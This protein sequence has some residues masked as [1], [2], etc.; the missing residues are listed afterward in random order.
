M[1]LHLRVLWTQPVPAEWQD[2]PVEF[3]MQQGKETLVPGQLQDDGTTLYETEVTAYTDAK[4]RLRYRGSCA[5]G[6]PEE[7][8][9][10]LSMRSPRRAGWI[11]RAKIM[12]TSLTQDFLSSLPDGS[13]LETRVEHLG[14]RRPGAEQ[15]WR[16]V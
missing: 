2:E 12:L 1:S 6:K 8:F 3:G 13:V 10:Y 4:G 16:R 7:P 9:L 11:M 5:Q 14:G 15:E